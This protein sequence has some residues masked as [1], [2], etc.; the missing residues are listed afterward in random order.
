MFRNGAKS[1]RWEE[2]QRC[3]D[4]YHK[5]QDHSEGSGIGMQGAHRLAD[6]ALLHQRAGDGQLDHNG[7]IASEEHGE[8]CG[9]IPEHGVVR[10]SLKAGAVVCRG[11]GILIQHLAQAVE[12]RV[13]DAVAS[14]AVR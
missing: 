11:R 1:Q 2:C 6:K 14:P 13:G 7:Q 10:Q 12:A 5:Y 4:V 8:T 3:E 9:D